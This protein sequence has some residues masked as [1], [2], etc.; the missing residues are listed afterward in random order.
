MPDPS[1][2][3]SFLLPILV[4]LAAAVVAVPLFRAAGMG[5]V[6]GYLAAGVAI[7]P[8]GL[9]L[10][11]GAENTLPV[12]ELGVVLLLFIIGLE[13]NPSR[14]LAMRRD[15]MA[16]GLSQMVVCSI[17]IGGALW[18]MGLDPRGAALAGI[19]LSFSG[20]AIALQ[21]L[22]E[23]GAV[24]SAYGRRSFAILI[25]QDILVVP[26]LAIVPLLANGGAG[27]GDWRQN[28]LAFGGVIAAFATVIFAGRFAINPFFGLLARSGAREVM[29]AGAL[30]VVLGA[31]V[32][33]NQAGMSM[34]LGAF[35]AGLLLSES[36]FRHQ[37]E[38]DIE[39]FR[40]MLM[41]LFFMSVGIAI[42]LGLVASN[43]ALLA[44]AA[45]AVLAVKALVVFTLMRGAGS[46]RCES[47]AG[48]SALTS[49]GEFSFVVFPLAAGA[50]L[51]TS[52]QA[53]ILTALAALTMV[54]GPLAASLLERVALRIRDRGEPPP[55][56]TPPEGL[57]GAALVIGFGRFGQIAVQVLLAGRVDVTVIDRDVQRI[58][59]A[60]RFGFKV[61]YGD[62]ARLDVLRAAG[63]A[64]AR[65]IAVCVDK[66]EEANRI[67]ELCKAEFPLA[68]IHARAYDRIHA[69][70]LIRRGADSFTRETFDAALAFGRGVLGKLSGDAES[71]EEIAA[72][73]R[74]R[75]FDR[76]AIQ[77]AGGVYAPAASGEPGVRP[78]PLTAPTR[79]AQALN[80]EARDIVQ[81]EERAGARADGQR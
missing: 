16:L 76:L 75:D 54:A 12:A 6:I 15:M 78:E 13:L 81:E 19:A 39:P 42:D 50:A 10:V 11:G 61:Y 30:F 68:E 9:G 17:L 7:G 26:V 23:R 21:I 4:F 45:L 22:E 35:L 71:A 62:G 74:Q 43:A 57:T 64:H 44:G 41:G 70:E 28:L 5:A 20:T 2:S 59:N 3:G 18:L 25:A 67:V 58:R 63:A 33:M 14:A 37:L 24:N 40:G 47:L 8:H 77:Q 38:A 36:H 65:V 79:R 53:A 66:A 72:D 46:T 56:E 80:E 32:L 60:A 51:L 29:T 48:A 69:L 73:V 49:A 27:G 34:A 1:H 52:S 55:S 31:A